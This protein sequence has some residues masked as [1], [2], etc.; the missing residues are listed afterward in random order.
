MDN[1]KELETTLGEGFPRVPLTKREYFAGLALQGILSVDISNQYTTPAQWVKC[2]AE[3]AV[4]FADA[5]LEE[6]K[7]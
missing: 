1:I 6:L 2:Q 3:A 5:L 7:K 4:E